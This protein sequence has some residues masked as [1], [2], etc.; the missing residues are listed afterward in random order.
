MCACTVG[1]S[2]LQ[3]M[4]V[5]TVT[6]IMMI[7][8]KTN[9]RTAVSASMLS[10]DTPASVQRDTGEVHMPAGIHK[11]LTNFSQSKESSFVSLFSSL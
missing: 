1:V 10:M 7:V 9:V 3:A 5:S 2:A 8:K 11:P 4:S 6:W